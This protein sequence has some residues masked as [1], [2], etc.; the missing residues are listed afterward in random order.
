VDHTRPPVSTFH[1][2]AIPVVL[3]PQIARRV[4]T[5]GATD[6][7]ATPFMV[8]LAAYAHLLMRTAAQDEVVIGVPVSGRP[9]GADEVIGLFVNA[10]PIRIHGEPGQSFL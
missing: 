6:R 8:L 2:H 9:D 4:T 7:G 10:L 1:G 5:A 3:D